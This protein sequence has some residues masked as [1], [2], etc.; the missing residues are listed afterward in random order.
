MAAQ[1]LQFQ[2]EH[3][4]FGTTPADPTASNWFTIFTAPNLRQP[5]A[6]G[7]YS[8]V[9]W[10]AG[11]SI[12]VNGLAMTNV[13]AFKIDSP[14]VILNG[15]TIADL[16]N[17]HVDAM[18]TFGATRHQALRVTGRSRMDGLLCHNQATLA[19]LVASVAALVLP[20]N[21]LGRYVILMD[22]DALGP[23][24]VQGIVNDQVGDMFHVVN[25][26]ANTFR[27]AHQDVAAV[28]ANRIISPTGAAINLGADESALL[29]YD[30]VATRWRI[31]ETTGA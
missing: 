14:V 1:G 28:A 11:G 6:A 23:W 24:D 8:D 3:I 10:T 20:A 13:A 7:E 17:L 12:D 9:L 21:N 5:S 22:A 27:L 26:G 4:S 29:W 30:P 16:S 31:M 19:T 15:G 2:L 18:P 25:T